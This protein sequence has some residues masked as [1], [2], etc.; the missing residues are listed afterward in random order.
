MICTPERDK[1]AVLLLLYLFSVP[2]Y[3]HEKILES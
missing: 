1:V 2:T 3:D